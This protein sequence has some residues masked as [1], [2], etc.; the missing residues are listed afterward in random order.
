MD[1][2]PASVALAVGAT[3]QFAATRSLSDGTPRRPPD[4]V[5]GNWR[6]DYGGGLYTAGSSVGA[7]GLSERRG[8]H[9]C[10]YRGDHRDRPTTTTTSTPAGWLAS[11][12]R[13]FPHQPHRPGTQVV[14]SD[15]GGD[16]SVPVDAATGTWPSG[17][18]HVAQNVY[19]AQAAAAYQASNLWPAPAVGQYLFVR[20]LLNNA[21]PS[22]ANT[23]GDHGFQANAT[24]PLRGSG[25][26]GVAMRTVSGSNPHVGQHNVTELQV[27]V[28]KNT[29][30]RL[31][32]RTERTR[33]STAVY[34]A[35]V[36]NNQTGALLG[37]I[38]LFARRP[39]HESLSRVPVRHE[40]SGRRQ[41]QRRL[42]LLGR[43]GRPDQRQCQ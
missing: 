12:V 33:P 29:V 36:Y 37:E 13:G 39:E 19:A 41:L 20:M 26:F 27:E 21:L 23:G 16:Q 22:S 28:P 18:T 25:A 24:H 7:T 4:D 31:E 6:H 3:R 32:W 2:T 42:G 17:L 8:R 15:H 9:L 11:L 14:H 5:V 34:T 10:R 40:R 35:R 30:L 1:V 38:T 43:H